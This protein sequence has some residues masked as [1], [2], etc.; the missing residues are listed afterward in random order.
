MANFTMK[1]LC[2]GVAAAVLLPACQSN[3][4]IR[5]DA[6]VVVK[7]VRIPK[8]EPWPSRFARH[9]YVEFRQNPQS[10]WRRLEIRTPKSGIEHTE[11][12]DEEAHAPVRFGEK[13]RVLAQFTP[14]GRVVKGARLEE[15][16][17]SYDD[18]VYRPW[19]G[20]NSNTFIE[21]LLRE[22]DGVWA[23]LEHN[24]VG[25]EHG[26]Y[27]GPTAGGTGLEVQTTY[28]GGAVGLREGVEIN[29]LG[30]TVGVRIWPPAIL[31]PILPE[32]PG[33]PHLADPGSKNE[34]IE[35]RSAGDTLSID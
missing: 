34:P 27:A 17:R 18:S 30:L 10:Q 2:I 7:D 6:V 29:L 9:S 31:I 22:T 24:A 5:P 14:E 15:L 4:T 26:L 28:L 25:K 13:V 11:I 16:A 12:T 20:P 33:R 19:P 21:H 1:W 32:I 23:V 3:R 35:S 8:T